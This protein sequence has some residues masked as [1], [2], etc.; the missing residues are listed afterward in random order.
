MS[1]DLI[2][3]HCH[4]DIIEEQGQN[5]KVSLEKSVTAGVKKL[6]QIGVDHKSSVFA[7]EISRKFG[8]DKLDIYYTIGCHPAYKEGFSERDEIISLIDSNQSD[9]KLVGIGE[10]GLDYYHGKESILA[11]QE[12]L[13]TLLGEAKE[14]KMPVIIHSR[15]AA[16][17]TYQAIKSYNGG[18]SGV[19]HCFTY[20]YEYGKKFADLGFFISF[21]GIVAFKNA[22]DIHDA[23]KKLPLDSILIETDAPFLAPPPF[24]GKRND[25]SN[26]VYILEKIFSLRD[27]SNSTIETAIFENSMKFITRKGR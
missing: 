2:D 19:I 26:L 17:D 22:T 10:V 14:R 9:P 20:D 6:V 13:S 4:L 18:I 23:A 21:S 15:D 16:A 12:I 1:Q 8:S 3:T 5:I 11:Q 7:K 25:P 27:E 24:R